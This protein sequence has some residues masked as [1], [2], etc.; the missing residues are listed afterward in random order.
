MSGSGSAAASFRDG[1]RAPAH[2]YPVQGLFV[3]IINMIWTKNPGTSKGE[4]TPPPVRYS[5]PAPPR[6]DRAERP[7]RPPHCLLQRSQDCSGRRSGRLLPLRSNG[8]ESLRHSATA[9][10]KTPALTPRTDRRFTTFR[11]RPP[12]TDKVGVESVPGTFC[13]LSVSAFFS[14][15]P[16]QSRQSFQAK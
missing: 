13:G 3:Y 1:R 4:S 7:P 9:P 2:C 8:T 16:Q 14:D 15:L 5:K 6:F 10:P 11:E 12:F